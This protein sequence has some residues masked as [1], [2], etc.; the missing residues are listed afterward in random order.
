MEIRQS[1]AWVALCEDYR[2]KF[3]ELMEFTESD[4]VGQD[5][6]GVLS[7]QA[8]E[9]FINL[10]DIV[11]II[12]NNI[13]QDDVFEWY[14]YNTE[15]WYYDIPHINIKSWVN[16]APRYTDLQKAKI[17]LNKSKFIYRVLS[18]IHSRIGDM[19]EKKRMKRV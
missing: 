13:S 18:N 19:L 16:G 14:E 7:C 4:W 3:L 2:K 9:F 17:I 8:C 5:V 6:G 10:D 11:F 12:D 1:T 15:C